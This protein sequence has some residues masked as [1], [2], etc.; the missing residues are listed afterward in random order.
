VGVHDPVDGNLRVDILG[1][2]VP[3]REREGEERE[4]RGA[5]GAHGVHTGVADVYGEG[6]RVAR[7]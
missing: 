1:G 4:E 6:A 7:F 5:S 2:M 3:V